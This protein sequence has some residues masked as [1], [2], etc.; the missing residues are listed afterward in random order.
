LDLLHIAADVP[1]PK[2]HF[3]VL[4]DGARVQVEYV[5]PKR[6]GTLTEIESLVRWLD[7]NPEIHSLL[8]IS[9]ST[10]LRRLRI[11]CRALVRTEID[12]TLSA[13]P[14]SPSLTNEERQSAIKSVCVALIEFS[15]VVLYWTLLALQ[16]YP[17]SPD[18]RC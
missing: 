5:R 7:Q 1:P 9:S 14:D 13:A 16:R 8:I 2:R 10:H 15:K 6:F 3:L 11:C 18:Q 12:V 17:R 4:F